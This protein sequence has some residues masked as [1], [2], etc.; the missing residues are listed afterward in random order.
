MLAGLGSHVKLV[1]FRTDSTCVSIQSVSIRTVS[2]RYGILPPLTHTAF[3][4]NLNLGII[5]LP[6]SPS[7]VVMADTIAPS[8]GLGTKFHVDSELPAASLSTFRLTLDNCYVT[9]V[10]AFPS[11]LAV[12]RHGI[13]RWNATCWLD[14]FS[15][16]QLAMRKIA[17]HCKTPTLHKGQICEFK[18]SQW[19]DERT[20]SVPD[21]RLLVVFPHMKKSFHSEE[22][23][24]EGSKEVQRIWTDKIVL[25]SIYRHVYSSVR[26]HLP[27]SY[28][29]LR[30]NS[31]A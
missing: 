1:S 18:G 2:K 21:I 12:F 30:L 24:K 31:E 14:Q 29:L 7:L 8:R 6:Y 4:T 3:R 15:I 9:E 20:Y 10:L 25:P 13:L 19:S 27:T 16:P 11:S 5:P 23:T 22:V 17:D 26:Q 28:K